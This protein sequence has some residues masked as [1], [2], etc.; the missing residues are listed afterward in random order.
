[1]SYLAETLSDLVRHVREDILDDT[2]EP[3]LWSDE[4]LE[5]FAFEALKEACRRAPLL[6]R[7]GSIAVT[8]GNSNYQLP[9]NVRQLLRVQ[10]ASL[11]EPL[12]QTS[13]SELTLTHGFRWQDESGEVSRYFRRG[14]TL[15]LYPTPVADDTLNWLASMV[16][17]EYF[18]LAEGE[19]DSTYYAPLRYYIAYQ[20]YLLSDVDSTHAPRAA[21]MLALFEKAFGPGK[22]A[23]YDQFAQDHRI[24][25]EWYGGRIA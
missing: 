8:S 4:Q 19:I 25:Q 22:T 7:S 10:L 5:R 13:E 23:R 15:T 12:L 6:I 2:E 16:P 9:V 11:P 1:M 21:E 18:E 24:Y 3:Y 14:R 17:D 20:A